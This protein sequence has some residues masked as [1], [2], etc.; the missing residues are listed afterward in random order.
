MIVKSVELEWVSIVTPNQMSGKYSTDFYFNDK[1]AENAL[2]KQI[3]DAWESHKGTHKGA[4]QSLG[5]TETEDGRIKFKATQAPK[6]NDGKYTFTVLCFDA[7][8]KKL[9]DGDI[10]SIGNGTIANVD[11]ELYPYTF[12]NNKGVKLNLKAIQIMDLKEYGNAAG[13]GFESGDGYEATPGNNF[14]DT[15]APEV[16]GV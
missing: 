7:K 12:K 10:P 5:Y 16:S 11:L 3:D 15:T 2:V 8:A 14:D 13:A 6:S 1:D 9:T 4:P